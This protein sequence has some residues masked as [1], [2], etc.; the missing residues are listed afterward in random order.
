VDERHRDPAAK[1]AIQAFPRHRARHH[2]AAHNDHVDSDAPHLLEHG[3][4]RGK[5]PVDVIQ[6]R[7]SLHGLGSSCNASK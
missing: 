7:D 2:V 4:E 6:G 5:V 1:E 3:L